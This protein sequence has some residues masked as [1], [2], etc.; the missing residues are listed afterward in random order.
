MVVIPGV[1]N[2]WRIRPCWEMAVLSLMDPDTTIEAP[3][4]MDAPVEDVMELLDPV[5]MKHLLQALMR[6]VVPVTM[7]DE[8]ESRTMLPVP[9]PMKLLFAVPPVAVVTSMMFDVPAPMN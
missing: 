5:A 6:F 4:R 3:E 8:P 2:D 1:S 7:A 9:D